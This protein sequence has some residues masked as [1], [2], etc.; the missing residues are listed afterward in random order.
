L[1]PVKKGDTLG[2]ERRDGAFMELCRMAIT[3]PDEN[4]VIIIDEINRGDISKIF[5]ELFSLIEADYRTFTGSIEDK[6]CAV[7]TQ[8]NNLWSD[9]A[10]D[11]GG[12]PDATFKDGFFVPPNIFIIGTMNDVDRSVESMDF[13]IRRRFSWHEVDPKDRFDVMCAAK[14]FDD[15]QKKDV[16]LR[17]NALNEKV[18]SDSAL[19]AAYQVGPAYF[20]KLVDGDYEGLWIRHLSLLFR[21]YLR[22]TPDIENRVEAYHQILINVKPE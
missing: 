19:G 6:V 2:F 9:G 15:V 1:R 3:H 20:M 17:M 11:V 10:P 5:G 13:A 14:G 12:S 7:K 18:R 4:F 22:G 8:Y 21:E 16:L